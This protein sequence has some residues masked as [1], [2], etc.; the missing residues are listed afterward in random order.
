MKLV[1]GSVVNNA[2]VVALTVDDATD[3]PLI[4]TDT[5]DIVYVVLAPNPLIVIG[6][7]VLAP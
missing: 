7:P 6:L 3:V 5:M 4:F 2:A 1:I